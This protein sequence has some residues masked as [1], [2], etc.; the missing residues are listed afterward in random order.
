M[1]ST[2]AL[3]VAPGIFAPVHGTTVLPAQ[4]TGSANAVPTTQLAWNGFEEHCKQHRASASRTDSE[5]ITQAYEPSYSSTSSSFDRRL[6]GHK[7]P[8]LF[9]LLDRPSDFSKLFFGCYKVRQAFT[10][11]RH[12]G[13]LGH[14]VKCWRERTAA[15]WSCLIIP[16]S[17]QR[18]RGRARSMRKIAKERP[19]GRP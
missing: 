11:R 6:A 17:I 5:H 8:A 1:R 4:R 19:K 16:I 7:T 3:D 15:C 10:D 12:A 2:V 13:R 18:E 14:S 9:Y